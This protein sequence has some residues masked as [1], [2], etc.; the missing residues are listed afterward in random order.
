MKRTQISLPEEMYEAVR[1]VSYEQR[2]SMAQIIR[3][4]LAEYLAPVPLEDKPAM[5]DAELEEMFTP[6][7]IEELKKN[8][9]FHIIGMVQ[10]DP[11][12]AANHDEI[13]LEEYP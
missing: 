7:E 4:A 1:R 10:A 5:D 3:E 6:E 9:L 13:Y 8:P 11:D 12:L 2:K